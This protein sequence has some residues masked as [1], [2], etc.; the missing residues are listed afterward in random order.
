MTDTSYPRSNATKAGLIMPVGRIKRQMRSF[1]NMDRV[2]ISGAI[3]IAGTMQYLIEELCELSAAVAL[4]TNAKRVTPRI[5]QKVIHDDAEL[6]D[7]LRTSVVVGGGHAL[8]LNKNS[9]FTRQLEAIKTREEKRR[10]PL[11][12][13]SP[14]MTKGNDTEV[15]D[16]KNKDSV[17]V[18]DDD[19]GLGINV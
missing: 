6:S 3:A 1:S 4:D 14:S 13:S 8:Y 10:S 9:L 19:D 17:N 15:E 5:I 12:S 16:T 11:V 18:S 7:L 2:S